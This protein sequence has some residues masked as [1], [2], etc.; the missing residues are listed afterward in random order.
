VAF[1]TVDFTEKQNLLNCLLD[2]KES[3]LLHLEV[4]QN[5]TPSRTT[6]IKDQ[7]ALTFTVSQ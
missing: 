7:A 4:S 6:A 3:T 5:S 2:L 1:L